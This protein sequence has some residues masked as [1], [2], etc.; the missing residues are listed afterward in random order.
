MK[1]NLAEIEERL[2]SFVEGSLPIF[3]WGH[4]KDQIAPLLMGALRASLGQDDQGELFAP[5]LLTIFVHPRALSDWQNNQIGLDALARILQD[6]CQE[7]GIRF[8]QPPVVRM[9][10]SYDLSVDDVRIN[11]SF[12]T[13]EILSHTAAID[14]PMQE[15]ILEPSNPVDAFLIINGSEIFPLGLSVINLGRRV[16]NH[17]VFQ[18]PKVSRTHAQLRAVRNHYVLFD[19]NSSGGTYVNGQRISQIT[20]KP[21]DVISLS[22]ISLIYGEDNPQPGHSNKTPTTDLKPLT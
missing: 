8:P 12:P 22:G 13:E 21:G 5:S 18:D 16:D 4:R 20:L 17:I 14:T 11:A 9:A 7:A 6:A 3:S 1:I 19:L 15:E 10:T 2:Q